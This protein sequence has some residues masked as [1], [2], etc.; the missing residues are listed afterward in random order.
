MKRQG[1]N[2]FSFGAA[3]CLMIGV[4]Y[5]QNVEDGKKLFFAGTYDDA[6]TQL[7]ASKVTVESLLWLSLVY[8]EKGEIDKA[9]AVF[10][11]VPDW[12]RFVPLINRV[13]E[14]EYNLGNYEKAKPL[15]QQAVNQNPKYIPGQF[16]LGKM[17]F[18]WGEVKSANE[19]F[20]VI[21][22]TFR[23]TPY[24]NAQLTFYTAKACVYLKR[25][26]DANDLFHDAHQ[27]D[28]NDWRI[29]ITWAD[30]FLSKFNY[31]DA[32]STYT[33]ALKIN[34]ACIPAKI[35]LARANL[36][37]NAE[38]S[39]KILEDM[40]KSDGGHKNVLAFAA[41][42]N[43]MANKTTDASRN[44]RIALQK[45]PND[46]ELLTISA[47]IEL[48]K[49]D[50]KS[51][52]SIENKVFR[53]NPFY[54][55]FW[56]EAGAFLARTY[57]FEEAVDCFSKAL[58]IDP[59]NEKARA[60]RGTALS[61]LARL[62][63]AK[64]DLEKAF[65][66][67]PYN[68]WT[69]NLLKLFD[70]YIEYDTVKTA[71]FII[72]MHEQDKPVIGPYAAELA[73]KAFA[74]YQSRYK[75]K[76]NFP[77]TIEIF[78]KHDDFAVRCFGLPGSQVFL[79][80]CFGPLVTMNSPRARPV[81]SFNWQETLWHEL[82]HVIHLTMTN[83]R[84]PR[85]L[86][87]GVAVW[88][89]TRAK[90][91][92]SMNME[93]MIIRAL[94]E[95][96]VIPIHELNRGFGGDPARVTF[97]YYQSSLMVEFIYSQFGMQALLSL[98]EEFKKDFTTSSALQNV[99]DLNDKQFDEKFLAWAKQE[100]S[101]TH[102]K[103]VFTDQKDENH[104]PKT[105]DDFEK[106]LEKDSSDFYA[107]LQVGT[108]KLA[109]N[110][111][112]GVGPLKRSIK[113]FPEYVSQGNGYWLLANYYSKA[114]MDEQASYYLK[115][116]TSRNGESYEANR[117]LQQLARKRKDIELEAFAYQNLI[118]I[119]PYDY[120]MHKN[121]GEILLTQKNYIDA[122]REFKIELS[123]N[124]TD[125]ASTHFRLAQAYLGDNQKT[126][127]KRHALKSLEIAP[128]FLPAQQLLMQSKTN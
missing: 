69:G 102:V 41:Q 119:Y 116:L 61:R 64:I 72:R 38:V 84:I 9:L 19:H 28:K 74:D 89:A 71:H 12:Q 47:L 6:I 63:E 109:K 75:F 101:Y 123:L 15:F 18:E 99:L 95:D 43:S 86:A 59:E 121:W 50:H 35:G 45:Y 1:R 73:E 124:P 31:P 4:L 110:D 87:E 56:A 16:N 48:K 115:E 68:V 80:I 17:L 36:D 126:R 125:L 113:L 23:N 14:I 128:T 42:L 94:Q 32:I 85:W 118:E 60:G 97:S 107:L 26:E 103:F 93:L 40:L 79:G 66:N 54:S 77:I 49:K 8:E 13:G 122:I 83:N 37:Q 39:F 25:F 62:D 88:E 21:I 90:R 81:G 76:I 55:D 34:P 112:S 58:K 105:M 57:L 30:L 27:L 92:W 67:D 46:L 3:I 52:Q 29:L 10:N 108:T 98:F 96:N 127:A 100:Y 22:N 11:N 44:I 91:A 7:K 2:L 5:A 117:L 20:N 51:F 104:P 114:K 24:P 82:A 53:I 33:D 65:K 120:E 111:S 70:S 106:R 78:P